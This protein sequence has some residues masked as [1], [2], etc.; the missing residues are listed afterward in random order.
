MTTVGSRHLCYSVNE[1]L[2]TKVDDT[3]EDAVKS[4]CW[5]M[6]HR[7]PMSGSDLIFDDMFKS[8]STIPF[9]YQ[10]DLCVQF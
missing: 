5:R 8:L 3:A 2:Q 9:K 1:D 7:E 4:L 10:E 6:P